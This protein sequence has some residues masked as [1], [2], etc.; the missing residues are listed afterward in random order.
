MYPMAPGTP[1]PIYRPLRPA[2]DGVPVDFKALWARADT[3]PQFLARVRNLRSLWEGSYRNAV[4]PGWAL[5]DYGTLSCGLR[6]LVLNADWCLDSANTVPILARLAE[7]VPRM[8]LRLLER[9]RYP[10]LMDRYLTDRTRSIPLV[11]LLDENFRELG[12]W[13]P[14]PAE[15]Q[16][17]VRAHLEDLPKE[18]RLKEQRRWYIRD[19]GESVLREVLER[20]ASE[21]L[22]LTA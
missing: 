14:R 15:L 4:L 11:I 22:K 5:G 1:V 3:F 21:C 18:E 8:E 12:H 16:S 7:Q 9:D 13:G 20:A 6:L 19:R 2:D 10:G 17:W